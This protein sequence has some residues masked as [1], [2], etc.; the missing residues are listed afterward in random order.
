MTADK[1][2]FGIAPFR[3]IADIAQAAPITLD[4]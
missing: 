4:L 2:N 3:D 1:N